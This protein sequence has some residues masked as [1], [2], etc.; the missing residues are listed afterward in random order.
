MSLLFA[1]KPR[2][3]V[4]ITIFCFLLSDE[5]V[6]YEKIFVPAAAKTEGI[7]IFIF[8]VLHFYLLIGVV[9]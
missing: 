6:N 7:F 2:N 3:N 9:A 8:L 1:Y 4:V 5:K